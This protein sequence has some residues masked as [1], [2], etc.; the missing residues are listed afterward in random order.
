MLRPHAIYEPGDTTLLPRLLRAHRFGR[1]L[2]VGDGR[3]RVSLTHVDNLVAAIA[4]VLE[5][6]TAHGIFN[7]ADSL[8]ASLDELLCTILTALGRAPRIGYLPVAVAWPLAIFLERAYRAANISQ[9]PP[10]TRY[11][12]SQLAREHTVDT[13]R[14]QQLLGYRPAR[15]FREGF[16][17]IGRQLAETAAPGRSPRAGP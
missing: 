15:S 13:S 4:A 12:V 7:V 16:A 14:A 9:P 17:E 2:A 1:L 8:D 5:R 11:L 6:P 10:L 3:N